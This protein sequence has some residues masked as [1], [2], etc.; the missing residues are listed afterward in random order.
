[1]AKKKKKTAAVIKTN[2][3]T[4]LAITRSGNTYTF[5]WTIGDGDYKDGQQFYWNLNGKRQWGAAGIGVGDT[6]RAVSISVNS[7]FTSIAFGVSGNR[8]QYKQKKKKIN[9]GWS[10]WATKSVTIGKPSAPSVSFSLAGN[11][12]PDAGTFSWSVPN[13]SNDSLY[14]FREYQWESI[15]VSKHNSSSPPSNWRG[16]MT[17]KGTAASYSKY[18]REDSALFNNPNYSY[19]RW[20]RIRSVGPAGVTGWH[21]SYHTYALPRQATGTTARVL[22]KS[23]ANGYMC[24]AEWTAPNSFMY[25]VERATVQYAVG[26]PH[27]TGTLANNKYTVSWS[28]PDSVSWSDAGTVGDT[29]GKDALT[30]SVDR[31]L[32][33]DEMLFVR[34]NTIHDH[35]TVEGPEVM[36]SGDIG[37]LPKA[38]NI[39]IAPNPSN[40]RVQVTATNPSNIT[41]SYIAIY[42][43]TESEQNKY[44]C[45]GILPKNQS[46]ITVQCPDWGDEEISI[47]LQPILADYKYDSTNAEY[48][49]SKVKMRSAEIQWDEGRI[50]MPPQVEVSALNP[51]TI[52]VI[53]DFPWSDA[54]QTELSWADHEDAWESTSE[55][56]SYIVNNLYGGQWNIAGVG[57]GTWYVR[58]RLLRVDGDNI[59][60][61][62]WSDPKVV[63]LSSA[64]AIPSL[65]L[66]DGIISPNGE[67]TCYWA[68]VSTDGTSQMQADICEATLDPETSTYT[69]G[70]PFVKTNMSQHITIMAKD[71]GWQAG[72]THY[73]AVRVISAS[74][75]QSQGWSTPQ[76]LKIAEA[77]TCSITSSSLVHTPISE[78]NYVLT[79][80]EEIVEGKTY[81]TR[82]GEEEPYT[83]TAV[84]SPVAMDLETYYEEVVRDVYSLTQLPLTVTVAGAG[85]GSQTS[86]SIIRA[87]S[88]HM[89]RPDDSEID[90]F[91][92]EVVY[93]RTFDGDGTFT[94][95]RGDLIG[96]LD[97]GASYTLIASAK[98][99]Y[100][101]TAEASQ[102][103]EVHW[104]HQA[105]VPT[106]LV[107]ID[108]EYDVA[109]MTPI[110]P[111]GVTAE[112]GDVCDIYRLSIDAPQLIYEGAA[113]G[114]RYVD[115]YPTI[116]DSG[117]YRFVY[118]TKDGDYT[119][120]DGHIAWFNT[121]ELDENEDSLDVF[122]SLIDFETGQ[123]ALPY[124]LSLSSKW[125]KDFQQTSYLGGHIQGDWNPAVSR[126]GSL[127]ATGIV[128]QEYGSDEDHEAIEAMR[129]LAMYP[130]ICHIR[131][132]DGSNY[133]AN[134][135]VQEDREEKWTT[136]LSKY[137]LDITRVDY[138]RLDGMTY[139]QWQ[140]SIKEEEEQ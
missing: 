118:R 96:Y 91:E 81:Y 117:G 78:G 40:H 65:I 92:G 44:K 124:N 64:P 71:Y 132:P 114:E 9:P 99:T 74:G 52:R 35:N 14:I 70:D 137:T 54:N 46:Q 5:S 19:T 102:N 67:V 95:N 20:F 94:I 18:I 77:I 98:D 85:L 105:T 7:N 43:R 110:L 51:T 55:P 115:P 49:L 16:A 112:E 119:T 66:S 79:T 36:A 122:T 83:Y 56:N 3:P 128:T 113:F 89:Y 129:R 69:Y 17:G 62:M 10:D 59:I 45:V 90:G 31:N 15:F 127:N 11:D 140:E 121:S 22:H 87:A 75:E 68:Y 63:K 27:T 135:N 116:G 60:Y 103:F 130:G 93:I 72:E 53:W 47:G 4:G 12:D 37:Y 23:G 101:Q 48:I 41:A 6:S 21:H 125:Q 106:G 33:E 134:V 29:G 42:F 107:S 32:D 38:T 26:S 30:F 86:I 28:V 82:S 84:P 50:P 39:T 24:I 133:A 1:M 109:I 100:G 123:V 138:Q 139:E 73:L 13:V 104:A 111:D 34:V 120:S 61:G 2:A 108:D 88:Y 97:D 131:T 57:V 8:A 80:D 58:A 25:P 76:A 126:T 136:K